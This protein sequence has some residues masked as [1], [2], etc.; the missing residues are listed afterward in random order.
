MG[1]HRH[2][3]RCRGDLVCDEVVR[4]AALMVPHSKHFSLP[5]SL[6]RAARFA[7]DGH[8]VR[9]AGRCEERKMPIEFRKTTGL[10]LIFGRYFRDK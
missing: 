5:E 10:M 6:S 7:R 9:A 8:D 4:P 2:G 3:S 1:G